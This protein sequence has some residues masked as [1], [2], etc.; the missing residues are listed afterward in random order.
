MTD[1]SKQEAARARQRDRRAKQRAEREAEAA[2][3]DQAIAAHAEYVALCEARGLTPM[4]LGVQWSMIGMMWSLGPEVIPYISP[5][6]EVWVRNLQ[7]TEAQ[8]DRPWAVA[9]ME[10]LKVGGVAS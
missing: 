1:L 10:A 8:H 5:S 2:E 4:P 7:H 6:G 3:A 9:N